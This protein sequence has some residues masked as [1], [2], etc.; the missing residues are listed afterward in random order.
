M[1]LIARVVPHG[2]EGTA[3]AIYA[4][5]GIGAATALLT[6]ASGILYARLGPSGFW[7]MAALS[8]AACGLALRLRA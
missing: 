7:I 8:A 4:T 5:V 6:F 3:Q 2:V 1:R